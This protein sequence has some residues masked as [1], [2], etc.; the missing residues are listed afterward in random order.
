MLNYLRDYGAISFADRALNDVDRLVF[1]QLVYLNFDTSVQDV[2]LS[3]ALARVDFGGGELSEVRFGFQ[4][5]DDR[6]LCELA[7]CPRYG[8]IRLMNAVRSFNP[9][10]ERQFAAMALR[11]PDGAVMIVFRGTDNTLAGW[12]E[13]FNLAFVDEIESQS[14]ACAYADEAAR[15]AAA[16]ELCGH[17]KGG[18]LA[19]Y[20]AVNCDERIQ[21]RI[22]DAVSFDGP[23]L[24]RRVIES[25]AFRRVEGRLRLRIPQ[26]SLVGLL[27]HQPE[28]VR[29]VECRGLS[30]LQHYPYFW[31]C[32]GMDLKY[33]RQLSPVGRKL[34]QSVCGT[35]EKLPDEQREELVEAIY[36]IVSTTGAETLNDLVNVWVSST[37][38]VL[39]RLRRMDRGFYRTLLKTLAAFWVSVAE[40]FGVVL[41]VN[42]DEW[43]R[44]DSEEKE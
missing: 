37:P 43:F 34:A 16:V 11:L 24:S 40:S 6:R 13:D 8:G 38:A 12:K 7:A 41:K 29:P 23:G 10:R 19:L 1:A 27:F 39:K 14:M 31:K 26:D 2:P 15:E 28:D 35:I 3:D 36:D 18:N 25:E 30:L 9:V 4:H 33:A 21:A 17:S 32:E 22:R 42:V 5:R 44:K 20:A